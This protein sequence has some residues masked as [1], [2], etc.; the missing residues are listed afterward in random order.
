MDETYEERSGLSHGI[1]VIWLDA[2]IGDPH[3]HSH[4]KAAFSS[5]IDPTNMEPIKLV[6]QDG[7]NTLFSNSYP[8]FPFRIGIPCELR[9]FV[10]SESCLRC[11]RESLNANKRIYVI[12]SDYVGRTLIPHIVQ[13]YPEVF[14]SMKARIS[15]YIFTFYMIDSLDWLYDYIDY[16]LMFDHEVDLLGRLVHDIAIYYKEIGKQLLRRDTLVDIH[17]ALIY[18]EWANA[19]CHHAR[20]ITIYQDSKCIED[21]EYLIG[22]AQEKIKNDMSFLHDRQYSLADMKRSLN[23]S[24]FIYCSQEFHNEAVQILSMLND[25]TNEQGTLFD[26]YD[27]FVAKLKSES[28][29][30]KYYCPIVISSNNSEQMKMLKDLSSLASI[31]HI[32]LLSPDEHISVAQNDQSL[33]ETFP[34]VRNIYLEAKTLAL[35]WTAERASTCEKIGEFCAENGDSDLARMYYKKAIKVNEH[36][37]AF[38]KNK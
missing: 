5:N 8:L 24:I 35:E 34:K 20:R 13:Q 31:N 11:V 29:T 21:L 32:Y 37:P 9:T 1:V 14:R 26:N 6:D 3:Y 19:L 28:R 33:L 16:A 7:T 27:A 38:I 23:S 18:F 30:I 36:L 4:L 22:Q 10:D 2:H 25:L 15:F 12:V 17:Q